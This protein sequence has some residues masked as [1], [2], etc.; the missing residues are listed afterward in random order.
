VSEPDDISQVTPDGLT[1]Y[2]STAERID[3][4]PVLLTLPH[5]IPPE[6]PSRLDT[7]SHIYTWLARLASWKS[8]ENW[9]PVEP[10]PKLLVKG[11][12]GWPVI[13]ISADCIVPLVT[14]ITMLPPSVQPEQPVKLPEE[15]ATNVAETSNVVMVSALAVATLRVS[16]NPKAA[17]ATLSFDFHMLRPNKNAGRSMEQVGIRPRHGC[18]FNK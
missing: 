17:S 12:T 4:Q 18:K 13:V 8:S 14:S 10:D 11:P 15:V 3:E 16:P 2:E 7:G 9:L 6:Y 5:M 1:V